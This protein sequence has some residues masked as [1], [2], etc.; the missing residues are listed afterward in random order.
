MVNKAEMVDAKKSKLIVVLGMHRSGTS[1]I[2]RGLQVLGVDLGDRMMPPI[3]GNNSKGFWEDI[4]LNALNIEML[5]AI[6]SDW[7][8]VDAIAPIDVAILQKKGY[9]LR[10]AELL[11]K[12]VGSTPFGFKDPRVAKL[13]PF[14]KSV[15]SYCQLDV[16]YVIA[17][18]HPLSVVMSLEKRDEF[19]VV[20]SYLL[21]LGHVI[22]SLICTSGENRVLI[23][24]DRMMLSPDFELKR[25]GDLIGLK[26]EPKELQEYKSEF[27]DQTLR[28]TVYELHD[29]LTDVRCPL[30][31]Q[32]I[33]SVLLDVT[34]DK[35]KF[36]NSEL[37]NKIVQWSVEFERMKP[38]LQLIDRLFS[39]KT[40]ML[41]T[42]NEKLAILNS[43]VADKEACILNLE[44]EWALRG[45]GIARLEQVIADQANQ[46]LN[47]EK[48]W[49][50]RGE[51]IARLEQVIAD[52]D[53]HIVCLEQT[54][55]NQENHIHIIEATLLK[56]QNSLYGK[57]ISG[58]SRLYSS[59]KSK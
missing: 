45:E 46:I 12:K 35:V 2:T 19:D 40:K 14:W 9:V 41:D 48:E 53:Q 37:Q 21:W 55:T 42:G 18:R 30:I 38:M 49:A 58:M 8:H 24:Y 23:D 4:D 52:R 26:V 28:H 34:I 1:A 29:L 10:A 56:F 31:V 16:S 25:I 50:L 57:C 11:R 22:T 33:Y 43:V 5:N 27:L 17:V 36:S 15:F 7:N 59:M 47:L 3:E 51:G 44:K 54:I 39:Q 13:L 32:D 6:E 20:Q